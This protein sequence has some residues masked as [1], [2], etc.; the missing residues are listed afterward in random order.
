M[1]PLCE[2]AP[3]SDKE[4]LPRNEP[5]ASGATPATL[6]AKK[7]RH[8]Q[9]KKRFRSQAEVKA[10]ITKNREMVKNREMNI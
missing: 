10:A 3:T 4:R 9:D 6:V 1:T 5:H 2:T 8:G 7:V